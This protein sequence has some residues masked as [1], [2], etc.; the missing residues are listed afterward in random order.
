M[1]TGEQT[2]RIDGRMLRVSR[3]D[4]VLY[5]E[6]G[7]TKGEVI[8]YYT[9]IA[10][11]MLPHLAQ[12]PVT[13][14]RWPEGVGT[15]AHPESSFFAKDLESS[16]P[17]WVRRQA[18]EHSGGPKDYPLVDD[19][20]TLAYLAQVASL[21]LH[22]PQWRFD[23]RGE[24]L[25][26]DRIVLDL[27]PG[28]GTGLAECAEVARYA[29]RI[30]QDMGLDPYPVTSG[31]KGIHLYA[32][33]PGTASSDEV[34]QVAKELARALEA[35][36]PDLVVSSMSKSARPGKV[37]VDWSQNNG[38]KTTI[39]PYSLRGRPHPMVA[40]PRTWAELDD[41]GLTHLDFREVLARAVADGDL[42]APLARPTASA[43]HGPLAPYI[44]K[45][46]ADRT[47]EPVPASAAVAPTPP[48]EAPR[49]V[50]Q[51]HHA[52]R[53][54]WD[55]R[56][57][58]DG[59]LVSWAVPKGVPETTDKNHL[60]VMTEDHPL[61]YGTFEG[62]I[63]RG[64]YGAGHV[65]I[66]DA[67]HYETEKWRDAEVIVTL[68][69]RPHGPLGT[70]RLALIRTGGSGE[71]SSWLL[72][73]MKE[74]Q[75]TPDAAEP[76][77]TT[78][79]APA[80]PADAAAHDPAD[81]TDIRPMLAT[82]A[83]PALAAAAAERWPGPPWVE[84]KW[85]G[86]RALGRWDGERLRLWAR[87][88][89][90]ITARYPELTAVDAGL[91]PDPVVVD[92]EIVA[93]DERGVPS[94]GVLQRRMHLADAREIEREVARTPVRYYLFDVLHH[95]GRSLAAT[96]LRDRRP[97]L[98]RAAAGAIDAIAVPPVFDDL[99]VALD[100]GERLGLEGVVVKNP[101][102]RYR[103]G[104]RS[105]D[106]LKVKHSRTQEVVIGGMRRGRGGRAGTFGSLLVGIPTGDGL[107]Y[108]GRVGTGF[109][110]A[111]LRRIHGM[112]SPL[113]TD[114]S[115]FL[116]V[117]REDTPD[118]VWVRPEVVGEVEFGEF[119][120]AGHLRHPRWRGLRPDKTPADV[121]PEDPAPF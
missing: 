75:P 10:P 83:T 85:D 30:L 119:T 26:P 5:P 100:D 6:T 48:G 118:A 11:L 41:P 65:T 104:S 28:P 76:A 96:P 79:S 110:D 106:W 63:P 27:D 52:R 99:R 78:S 93:L 36:H 45:R 95:A 24:R 84:M 90:D 112:L 40:A 19:V 4:K 51:E 16:A 21:E 9:R 18:I 38:S 120:S 55:F 113:V 98:E 42:L 58:R 94:F 111:A 22:T 73:R 3:L 1:A 47:P 81:A 82:L 35:D 8:D 101:S 117:P 102:S 109:T 121:T 25:P 92:G 77:A 14:K 91:G 115:P 71:K 57:E 72:H 32:T 39:A 74:Q 43:A 68:H 62:E 49:F 89:I 60:A 20:A 103:S 17:A 97:V 61:D 7:T 15:D 87:S 114:A 67:G 44:A 23:Q 105:D 70:A 33:L 107:R 88:G 66:W 56:L 29:R 46:S 108:V 64:E 80:E 59:V 31:S 50:I 2:V 54:H 34:S 13:R 37:F 69:G 86:V 12:R 53:L 116:D